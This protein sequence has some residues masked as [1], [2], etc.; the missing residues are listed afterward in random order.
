MYFY[1]QVEGGNEEWKLVSEGTA[2][3]V[4]ANARYRTVLQTSSAIRDDYGEK[5]FSELRYYGPFYL[6]WD[7]P[8]VEQA[9]DKFVGFLTKLEDKNVDL[10]SLY[11]YATGGRGFHCEIPPEVFMEKPNKG[12]IQSLPAIYKEMAYALYTDHMDLR[13]Y[14]AR[15][16]RMWR[17]PNVQRENGYY[18]VPITAREAFDLR[19]EDYLTLCSAPR[20]QP[21]R[22][23]PKLNNELA[24]LYA[25]S[26]DK[27]K[28]GAKRRGDSQKDKKL[29]ARFKGEVPPSIKMLLDGENIAEDATFNG[30]ALQVTT[31]MHALGKSLEEMLT[32][33][34]GLIACDDFSGRYNSP[35]RREAELVRLFHYT[36]GNPCYMYSKDALKS[37]LSVPA[38]DLDGVVTAGDAEEIADESADT[39]LLGGVYITPQGIYGP[40]A[41]GSG[42]RQLSNVGFSDVAEMVNVHT[43]ECVAFEANLYWDGHPCK[44]RDIEL[45]TFLSR[46]RMHQFCVA[47]RGIFTGNDNQAAAVSTLLRRAAMKNDRVLYVTNREGLDLIPNAEAPHG[48]DLAWVA[49]TEVLTNGTTRQYHFRGSPK[50]DGHYKSDL[51]EAPDAEDRPELRTALDNLLL[52]NEPFVVAALI[53]WLSASF[54]KQLYQEMFGGFPL[55]Q[56]FGQ[57][58]AG[59][60]ATVEILQSFFYY[61]SR[62]IIT[63]VNNV[64]KHALQTALWSSASIPCV[65]DEYKPREMRQDHYHNVLHLLR[66]AYNSGTISKGGLTDNDLTGSWRDVRN[67]ALSAPVLFMG[68]AQE[69]QTEMQ[70]RSIMVPLKADHPIAR[71]Q[72]FSYCRLH[73]KQFASI[74]KSLVRAVLLTDLSKFQD[75]FNANL[76]EVDAAAPDSAVDRVRYNIAVLLTGFDFFGQVLAAHFGD[77]YAGRLAE[78]RQYLADVST[79]TTANVMSEPAKVLNTLALISRTEDPTSE[80]GLLYGQDYAFTRGGDQLDIK[81]RNTYVKYVTWCRRKGITSLYDDEG[82]FIQGLSNFVATV[83]RH[84]NDSVLKETGLT[85]VFRFDVQLLL[86]EGIEPFQAR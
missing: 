5:E 35:K 20:P 56:L 67:I 58:G 15:K 25:Q 47:N 45:T 84:A 28:A 31:V 49:P 43:E 83:D 46:A 37:V 81:L 14:S 39:S 3:T 11:L 73:R 68:T 22:S 41:D 63:S 85:K 51:M 32:L 1:Y 60:T 77:T 9:L 29:L 18:K 74:G 61:A 52:I 26:L 23:E 69:S 57:A 17:Q 19:T 75:T 59:K 4:P 64:T 12:G 2:H 8:S 30:V 86:K 71:R 7:A 76:A 33:A 48:F 70:E 78:L 6:D 82:A 44:R 50:K 54:Q 24:I 72:A 27:I 34:K 79:Y 40:N 42:I 62:P 36:E 65:L 21:Q 16:G 66:T 55:L 13:I 53:G 10:D 38:R 80:V